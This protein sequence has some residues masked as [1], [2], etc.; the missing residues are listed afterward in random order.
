MSGSAVLVPALGLSSDSVWS[1]ND[2][3]LCLT[4]SPPLFHVMTAICVL[5]EMVVSPEG[6]VVRL[7]VL[8]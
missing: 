8:P 7:H 1:L 4:K 3:T 5:S 2:V 6:G